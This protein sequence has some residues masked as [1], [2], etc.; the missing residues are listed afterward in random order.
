M[1][2]NISDLEFPSLELTDLA[3]F[4]DTMEEIASQYSAW[5]HVE[6]SYAKQEESFELEGWCYCCA[7]PSQFLADYLYA[8]EAGHL[9]KRVPNWRERLLC[10][11]CKLNNRTRACI[12]FLEQVSKVSSKSKIYIT[13][14]STSLY[15][16]LKQRYPQLIG[17]EYIR[18]PIAKGAIDK[19]TGF[20]NENVTCLSFDDASINYVLTFDVLE[21]VPD[22]KNALAEF[23]RVLATGGMLVFTVPFALGHKNNI[24]R[25][26]VSV[27]GEIKHL[28]DPEYHGDPIN[29]EGCLCFYYFGWQLLDELRSLGFTDAK[30]HYY[31]SDAYV[32]LGEH[33]V[34]FSAVKE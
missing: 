6:D 19:N 21:H 18:E 7:C 34:I 28:M 25:A 24:V 3:N 33:Q 1:R 31:W 22:Y 20:R 4:R 23:F 2:E 30:A 32:Y 16:A 5:R 12:H 27:D 13:E 26:E 8:A 17:S 15:E 14:Q 9:E 11:R 29:D 10:S